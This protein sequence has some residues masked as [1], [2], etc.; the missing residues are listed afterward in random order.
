MTYNIIRILNK[1][2][3]SKNGAEDKRVKKKIFLFLSLLLI[4]H[5]GCEVIM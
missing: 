4:S 1:K 5:N 3:T 2:A